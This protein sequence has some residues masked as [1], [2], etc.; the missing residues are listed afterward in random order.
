MRRNQG[1]G[2]SI[3]LFI[4]VIFFVWL[5]PFEATEE[6][7]DAD[8]ENVETLS[9]EEIVIEGGKI[10]DG[11]TMVS[12]RELFEAMDVSWEEEEDTTE[13]E[14]EE[15]RISFTIGETAAVINGEEEEMETPPAEID[16]T[17]YVP[18]RFTAEAFEA[19][20]SWLEEESTVLIEDNHREIKVL[21]EGDGAEEAQEENDTAETMEVYG[22][23][24]GDSQSRVAEAWGDPRRVTD[25]HYSFEWYTYHDDYDNF[26]KAGIVDGEVA[27]LYTNTNELDSPDNLE[28]ETSRNEVRD[29]FGE[30]EEAIVKGATRYTQG[31]TD[32]TDLFHVYDG[33]L[34]IYYDV[35]REDAATAVQLIDEEVEQE[36]NG[37]YGEGSEELAENFSMQMFDLVNADRVKFDEEPLE[38]NEEVA[39]AALGHSEDMAER[40]YFG[41]ESP[42]G[43]SPFDRLDEEGLTYTRAGENIAA[44]QPS[45]IMAEQGLMNSEGHR[46]NILSSQFEELGVGTDFDEED[47]P[48]FTQKFYTR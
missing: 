41:H 22:I 26:R 24:L 8:P 1:G 43:T 31:D 37:Y 35:H 47:R 6:L 3:F 5:Y 40:G 30:P 46:R 28:L 16:D 48:F 32:E 18:V 42:E 11:H 39:R 34:T 44:G 29:I 27:A 10:E 2:F 14:R 36:L 33:Y 23:S 38:W 7:R 12:V 13:A 17:V 21:I 25:S 19:E 20:V 4:G 15:E 45:A 9:T